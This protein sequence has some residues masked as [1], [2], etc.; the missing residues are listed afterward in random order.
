MG[1]FIMMSGLSGSGKTTY[2]DT[3]LRKE[4]PSA[5]VVNPDDFYKLMNGDE[6][7][8]KNEFEIWI[9][10]FQTLHMLEKAGKDIIFDSNNLTRGDR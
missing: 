4:Y 9:T 6:T 7:I 3:V 2:V 8:H 1:K 5:V 10:I